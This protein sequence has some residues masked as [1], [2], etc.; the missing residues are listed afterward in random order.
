[1]I[2]LNGGDLAVHTN[3]ASMCLPCLEKEYEIVAGRFRL[4]MVDSHELEFN[5]NK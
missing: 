1:M 5:S 2:S 3:A 4:F